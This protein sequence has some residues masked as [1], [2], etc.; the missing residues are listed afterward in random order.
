MLSKF[1]IIHTS[2]PDVLEA[3]AISRLGVV[4]VG[5]SKANAFDARVSFLQL[6]DTAFGFSTVGTKVEAIFPEVDFARL[7]IVLAGKGGTSVD[8][9]FFRADYDHPILSTPGT[10][11]IMYYEE[12]LA[13]IFVRLSPSAICSQLSAL[14][15]ASVYRLPEF[16]PDVFPDPGRVFGLRQLVD[17]FVRQIDVLNPDLVYPAFKE[18]QQAIITQ[19]LFSNQHSLS[20]LLNRDPAQSSP[21]QV[22]RAEEYIEAHW[23]QAITIEDLVNVSGVSARTLF[24][25]FERFRGYPPMAFLKKTRLGKAREILMQDTAS[26]SVTAVAFRCGFTNP[27]QFSREYRATFGELPSHTLQRRLRTAGEV[28]RALI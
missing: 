14:L 27:G 4:K 22:K 23:H 25:S 9:R 2:N 15:G 7:Q 26:V 24:R 10:R 21:N 13:Q 12:D 28:G 16:V 1:R 20:E 5:L 6:E 19:V 17:F 18:L 8:G 11:S 3:E